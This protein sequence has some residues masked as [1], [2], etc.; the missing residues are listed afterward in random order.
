MNIKIVKVG[1]L[2]TNCYI[3]E[4]NNESIIIDPG[5]SP[6][7]I[8][9]YLTK[10]LVGIIITHGH[11]DHI[12]AASYFKN[13]Y[14]VSIYNFNNLKE[15]VNNIGGFNFEILYTPG[16]TKDSIVIYFKDENKM[17]V[18]DFIFYHTI[19]RTDLEGGSYVDMIKSIEKIKKYKDVILYPGHGTITNIDEEKNNNIYFK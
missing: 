4:N 8:E 15:G 19:G 9:K 17:F 2:E 1:L 3:I 7:K 6:E 13:K 14:N 5:D 18:G 16:H 11:E 10:K 12:G